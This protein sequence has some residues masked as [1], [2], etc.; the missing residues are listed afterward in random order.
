LKV[1]LAICKTNVISGKTG[2]GWKDE[3]PLPAPFHFSLFHFDSGGTE[4]VIELLL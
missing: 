3:L 4:F 1:E 2:T